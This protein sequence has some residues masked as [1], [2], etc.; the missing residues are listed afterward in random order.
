MLVWGCVVRGS[1]SRMKSKVLEGVGINK[2]IGCIK[3][4][5]AWLVIFKA[6]YIAG[7]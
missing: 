1:D 4:E 6:S 2:K 3:G 5:Q 7:D